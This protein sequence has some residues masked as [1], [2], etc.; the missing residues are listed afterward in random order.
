MSSS[1]TFWPPAPPISTDSKADE[2]QLKNISTTEKDSIED[3]DSDYVDPTDAAQL[4][5]DGNSSATTAA[6]VGNI[7]GHG[8]RRGRR[9]HGHGPRGGTRGRGCG[10]RRQGRGN[11][12][13]VAQPPPLLSWKDSDKDKD[14]WPMSWYNHC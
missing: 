3:D 10:G 2:E 12:N 1:F 14:S 11:G 8:Q 9:G 6:K 5:P 13:A 7:H 4:K